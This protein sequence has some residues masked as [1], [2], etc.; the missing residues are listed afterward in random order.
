PLVELQAAAGFQGDL[1]DHIVV[2]ENYPITEAMKTLD[3]EKKLGFSIDNIDTFEQTNYGLT[4]AIHPGENLTVTFYYNPDM[5]NKE[6]MTRVKNHLLNISREAAENPGILLSRVTMLSQAEEKQL[7][8]EFNDTPA[9]YPGDKTIRQLFEEQVERTPDQINI[10]GSGQYAV[11]IKKLKKKKEKREQSLQTG[12]RQIRDRT[13]EGIHE[14]PF[15]PPSV[16]PSTH[17]PTTTSIIQLTYRELNEQSNRLAVRL[18]EKGVEAEAVV[19]I[20]AGRSIEMMIGIMGIIKAGGAYLPIDPGYPEARKRF[21][22]KDSAARILLSEPGM[23][24]ELSAETGML[25]EEIEI[26]P[27]N[28]DSWGELCAPPDSRQT[29]REVAG[30][31]YVIYT[32]GSSGFPKGVTVPHRAL[33]NFLYSM[34][35]LYDEDFG[36]VDNCLSLTSL[37]FDVSV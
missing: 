17:L 7:L 36:S 18:Q 16:L 19:G 26:I 15:Q 32:S 4:I 5:Y 23:S 6:T 24:G 35:A 2:F 22:L 37:S 3:L 11:G 28:K 27:L 34:Y 31:V 33:V 21:M 25:N 13:V 10:V 14:S 1:S 9:E 30:L 20:M 29:C 8:Y 12:D